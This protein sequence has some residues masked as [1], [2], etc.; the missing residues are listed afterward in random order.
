VLEITLARTVRNRESLNTPVTK[1][2]NK[3]EKEANR[4]KIR[5]IHKLQKQWWLTA[6]Y[7]MTSGPV[8]IP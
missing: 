4:K 2:I 3:D 1:Y 7:N 8:K 6:A 5:H